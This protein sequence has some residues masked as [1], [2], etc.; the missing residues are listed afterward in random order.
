MKIP[1]FPE[2][3]HSLIEAIADCSDRDLLMQFQQDPL[4]GRYF[5]ALFCR[6]GPLVYSL[7][8]HAAAN[9]EE[10]GYRFAQVWKQIYADLPQ[11]D[12]D[13][14]DDQQADHTT[15][16][17]ELATP[18]ITLQNWIVNSATRYLNS[19]TESEDGAEQSPAQAG[20]YALAY[21]PPPLWCYLDQAIAQLPP[22]HRLVV[23]LHRTFGW[24]LEEVAD[25]LNAKGADI[26]PD[27]V[28]ALLEEGFYQL[29]TELPQDIR[30]IY[31]A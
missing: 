8:Q 25:Y 10:A 16:I 13:V 3:R 24:P 2:C 30:E 11:L 29:D 18:P 14:E 4:A 27:A 15:G 12:L 5:V 23:I 17:A 6:Y 1:Q 26:A 31:L 9:S 28:A 22:L 20:R 7:V 19:F 21:A